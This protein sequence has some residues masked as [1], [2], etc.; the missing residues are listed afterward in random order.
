MVTIPR[1]L[2]QGIP[3]V[4]IPTVYNSRESCTAIFDTKSM[5]WNSTESGIK[6]PFA[7]YLITGHYDPSRIFYVGGVNETSI[8]ELSENNV[9]KIVPIN[10]P[11][12]VSILDTHFSSA[13]LN[14][15]KC[16]SDS[17]VLMDD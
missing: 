1:V 13:Q 17:S 12:S 5:S 15:T 10:L 14:T 8:L 7:G 16:A 11:F 9:W 3:E 6:L 4:V 2:E